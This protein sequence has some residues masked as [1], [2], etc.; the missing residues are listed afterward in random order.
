MRRDHQ[1]LGALASALVGAGA[2]RSA[3]R[4]LTR[5]RFLHASTWGFAGLAAVS[6]TSLVTL[7]ERF[8]PDEVAGYASVEATLA[9][10]ADSQRLARGEPAAAASSL[11]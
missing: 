10:L 5:R 8:A 4:R 7:A 6:G 3:R 9:R 1:R 11:R 2:F